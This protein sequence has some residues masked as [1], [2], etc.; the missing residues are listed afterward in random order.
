[1]L[2]LNWPYNSA[3]RRVNWLCKC[4]FLY[5]YTSSLTCIISSTPPRHASC[6]AVIQPCSQPILPPFI[7]FMLIVLI[8]YTHT[9]PLMP[10]TVI[11]QHVACPLLPRQRR[12]YQLARVL[13][14]SEM[15]LHLPKPSAVS[16]RQ[17]HARYV[18]TVGRLIDKGKFNSRCSMSGSPNQNDGAE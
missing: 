11:I 5:I 4:C 16:E 8:T 14:L 2:I 18:Q 7:F 17:R 13:G 9:T 12:Y 15:Q 10:T 6:Y 1:M 3:V